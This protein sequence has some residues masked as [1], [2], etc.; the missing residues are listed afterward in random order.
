[1]SCIII[2]G[3]ILPKDVCRMDCSTLFSTLCTL[4]PMTTAKAMAKAM[5]IEVITPMTIPV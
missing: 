2:T 5:I 1:M 4:L 3:L